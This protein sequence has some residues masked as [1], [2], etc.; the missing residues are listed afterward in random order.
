MGLGGLREG[1]ILG[2]GQLAPKSTQ[3]QGNEVRECCANMRLWDMTLNPK[4]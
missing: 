2:L 1:R 4:P 3:I